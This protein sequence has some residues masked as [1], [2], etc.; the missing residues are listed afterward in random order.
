MELGRNVVNVH[1]GK[2]CCMKS[3]IFAI[4]RLTY[5]LM[6]SIARDGEKGPT[7]NLYYQTGVRKAI[8]CRKKE[9]STQDSSSGSCLL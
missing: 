9:L 3:M 4:L 2:V 8:G 1:L 5:T 7:Q 6:L